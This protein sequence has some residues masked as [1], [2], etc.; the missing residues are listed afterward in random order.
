MTS[1]SGLLRVV[2]FERGDQ[3]GPNDIKMAVAVA[4]LAEIW[5]VKNHE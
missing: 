5:S 4:V 2:S 3:G 1:G